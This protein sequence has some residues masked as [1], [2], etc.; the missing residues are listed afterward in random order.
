MIKKSIT[1]DYAPKALGPYSQAIIYGNMIYCSGQLGLDPRTGEFIS[2]NDIKLQTNQVIKN[3]QNILESQGSKLD[4]IIKTSIFLSDINN[5]TLVN[6]VYE[7]FFKSPYPARSTVE[8]S[9]LPLNAL[10]EIEAIASLT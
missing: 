4:N 1:T 8:V 9:C 3:I 6:Q 10:V 7:E 2:K 5:F